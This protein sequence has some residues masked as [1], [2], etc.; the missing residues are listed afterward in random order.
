MLFWRW[1]S[2]GSRAEIAHP[3]ARPPLSPSIDY[4]CDDGHGHEAKGKSHGNEEEAAGRPAQ[5]GD[6]YRVAAGNERDG[7]GV[8][9]SGSTR[10]WPGTGSRPSKS[11]RELILPA[12]S[13][14]GDSIHQAGFSSLGRGTGPDKVPDQT[15]GQVPGLVGVAASGKRDPGPAGSVAGPRQT[16]GRP[17]D[18]TGV[19]EEN[20]R[21]HPS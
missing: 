12:R 14:L 5:P 19:D 11:R 18:P 15:R 13:P 6:G 7:G 2:A 3:H 4:G 20:G 9:A 10:A 17:S 16:D 8:F 21:Q 1:M